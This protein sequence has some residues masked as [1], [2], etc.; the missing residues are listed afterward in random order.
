MTFDAETGLV[1][2]AAVDNA[3][4]VVYTTDG[5]VPSAD[6]GTVYKEPFNVADGTTVKA[7]ALGDEVNN[8]NSDVSTVVVC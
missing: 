4:S 2:I 8:S 6:N 1:T 7:I 5:S 3:L